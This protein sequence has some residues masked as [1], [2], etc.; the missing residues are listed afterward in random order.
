[1]AD[2]T[3]MTSVCQGEA[4]LAQVSIFAKSVLLVV[5]EWQVAETREFPD[6]RS[7]MRPHAQHRQGRRP[8]EG[9]DRWF[10]GG[11]ES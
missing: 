4:S 6:C 10:D 1:M 8:A 3:T 11:C 9:V 7:R 2:H 5:L